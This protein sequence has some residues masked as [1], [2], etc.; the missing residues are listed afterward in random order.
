MFYLYVVEDDLASDVDV[1][2]IHRLK[3]SNK[4]VL[5]FIHWR[6]GDVDAAVK[7]AVLVLQ[8]RKKNN[9]SGKHASFN[10]LLC[11]F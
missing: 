2:D 11:K 1:K 3:A 10:L 8:W 7:M 4:Y 9:I 6:R 5:C